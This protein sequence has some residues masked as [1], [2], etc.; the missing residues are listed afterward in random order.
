MAGKSICAG[1][2]SM[3]YIKYSRRS[4]HRVPLSGASS[5]WARI[6]PGFRSGILGCF[7][8]SD[9]HGDRT[10]LASQLTPGTYVVLKATRY[11]YWVLS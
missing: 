8:F 2:L 10:R 4:R 6:W 1:P 11:A 9:G 5:L 7:G 3:R